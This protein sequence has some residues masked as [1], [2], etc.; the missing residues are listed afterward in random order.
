MGK[1]G[2]DLTTTGHDSTN[3]SFSPPVEIHDLSPDPDPEDNSPNLTQEPQFERSLSE[4]TKLFLLLP[5][6]SLTTTSKQVPFHLTLVRALW[7]RDDNWHTATVARNRGTWKLIGCEYVVV[8]DCKFTLPEMEIAPGKMTSD[9]EHLVLW[10]RCTHPPTY[11]D[12]GQVVAQLIPTPKEQ[13]TQGLQVNAVISIDKNRPKKK[14]KL[15]V[16]GETTH[17][18]GLL[19][20]GA[21]VTIISERMWLSH[22]PL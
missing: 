15:S 6:T 11:L 12:K 13:E 4:L 7:L 3:Q 22:W 19:D 8:G 21:D 20:T 18:N 9:P 5:E 1:R 14:C 17:I 10:L 16:G 2:L